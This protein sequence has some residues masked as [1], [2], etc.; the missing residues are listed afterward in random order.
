[1]QDSFEIG[2][3]NLTG[4]ISEKD[5][6]SLS[7]DSFFEW[8]AGLVSS[9][10]SKLASFTMHAPLEIMARFLL[11]HRVAPEHQFLARLQIA[12]SATRYTEIGQSLALPSVY[13]HGNA[14][15]GDGPLEKVIRSIANG[16][17]EGT[18]KASCEF[19]A[20]GAYPL[21]VDGLADHFVSHFSCGAHSHIYL[22]LLSLLSPSQQRVALPMLIGF[23]NELSH[24]PRQVISPI[25]NGAACYKIGAD[26]E[27]LASTILN[28]TKL[29]P[30]SEG[31]ISAMVAH[32]L[33]HKLDSELRSIIAD[34]SLSDDSADDG[35]VL[36]CRI[37]AHSMIQEDGTHTC[38][39][40]THALT[41]PQ[42]VL[43]LSGSFANPANAMLAS[44]LYAISYQAILAKGRQNLSY[45]PP[46]NELSFDEALLHSPE[47]ALAAGWHLPSELRQ[48]A[49]GRL[50]TEACIRPD[51]HCVKYVL[52]AW[53]M[54]EFDA[55]FAHLYL[56]A[57][58]RLVHFWISEYP[59]NEIIE[60]LKE[61]DDS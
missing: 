52:A 57:A 5:L 36:P 12:A 60:R 45:L 18:V 26:N 61:R 2:W 40:W 9:P 59:H 32:S 56:A 30:P 41:L 48:V 1:M 29:E 16:D 22:H 3:S 38:Y 24:H 20:S 34:Q 33:A 46:S 23:A 55:D 15:N 14:L 10:K 8:A 7:D 58:C 27:H 42:A 54:A 21:L 13:T 28:V 35:F 51:C 25:E 44:N 6:F 39:G 53:Q 37:A 50:A 19:V 17:V 49:F 43:G 11:L 4:Q 31:G 47:A